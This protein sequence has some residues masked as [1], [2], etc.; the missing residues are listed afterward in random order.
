MKC[1]EQKIRA[2]Y[3]EPAVSGMYIT[4]A[5]LRIFRNEADKKG[6]I[7]K[8][9]VFHCNT[10]GRPQSAA[11]KGFCH[12]GSSFFDEHFGEKLT[13]KIHRKCRWV[14]NSC[15]NYLKTNMNFKITKVDGEL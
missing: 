3:A 2:I 13:R 12:I 4:I 9:V 15:I 14:T 7:R 6:T 11:T 1:I 5:N 8:K 10:D